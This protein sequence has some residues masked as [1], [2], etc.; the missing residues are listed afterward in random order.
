[1][2]LNMCYR[3][4]LILALIGLVVSTPAWAGGLWLYEAATPD[5]GTAAAGRA[6]AANDA[7]TA[8]TNPAGMTRLDRTQLL[9]GFEGLVVRAK[10][11][12]DSSSFSGGDGGNAGDFVP[13]ASLHYVANVNPNLRLGL[14]M[15]SYFGLGLD[16]DDDWAGRY[17]VQE[18][19]FTTLGINPGVGYRVNNWLSI[20]AGFSIVYAQLEQ[21]T[22]INNQV[23]D[24]GT[25]DGQIKVK[26]DDMGYGWNVGVLLEPKEGTRFGATYRSEVDVN[27]KDVAD[28]KGLGPNLQALLTLTGVIGSRVDLE[29]TIPQAV[30]VSGYHELTNRL[31]IMAN[32]GWQ[33]W[34]EFGKTNV[35]VS[36]TSKTRLTDDRNFKDTWHVALGAQYRFLEDWL[37]S[38]GFAYD[39]SPVDDNDRT[40]DMPLDRQIRYAT[41][42]QYDWGENITLGTAYEYLD[43]GDAK[44][45]QRGGPL[46]GDLKG[47][48]KTN[49]IHVFNVN[50][51][52]RF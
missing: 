16:Y 51:I 28:L 52:W 1:M 40:P 49:E 46:R 8:G 18:A 13:V 3:F 33:D 45:D 14:S 27:F 26:D 37:W 36:S 32:L 31:A 50:A 23:T 47:D 22:A 20:G 42:L 34:S 5:V 10:F 48:Y 30:M 9:A 43:A 44:I 6:A 19:E 2:G 11:D 17:Y 21:K 29:M 15:G 4:V 12:T 38:I 24:P 7:S 35:T 39:S 41:G 25:P